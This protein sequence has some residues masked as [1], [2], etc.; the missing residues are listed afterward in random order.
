MVGPR[1]I[2]GRGREQTLDSVETDHAKTVSCAGMLFSHLSAAAL[3]SLALLGT[4]GS[5]ALAIY[6]SRSIHRL[7]D[8]PGCGVWS[9]NSAGPA[10]LRGRLTDAIS[11]HDMK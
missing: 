7:N 6:L 11:T 2:Q 4:Y 8:Q 5:H 9:G 1:L 3:S 10:D